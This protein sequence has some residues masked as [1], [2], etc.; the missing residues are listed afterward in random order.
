MHGYCSSDTLSILSVLIMYG[1]C[2]LAATPNKD[3]NASK[4]KR[5]RTRDNVKK[6]KPKKLRNVRII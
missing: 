3:S 2:L 1:I 4:S 6:I 5:R